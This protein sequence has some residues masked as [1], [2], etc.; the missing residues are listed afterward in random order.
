[1]KRRG[2]FAWRSLDAWEILL[3][4]RGQGWLRWGDDDREYVQNHGGPGLDEWVP[5]TVSPPARTIA[6]WLLSWPRVPL[7]IVGFYRRG[8]GR[9]SWEE[10]R[11]E[12][13]RG[14]LRAARADDRAERLAGWPSSPWKTRSRRRT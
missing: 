12:T 10:Y 14:A 6:R 7:V 11:P 8:W 1:M 3:F 13:L 2:R 9:L 5:Y 4:E